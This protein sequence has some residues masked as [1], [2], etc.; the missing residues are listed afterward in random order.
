MAREFSRSD[1]DEAYDV[2]AGLAGAGN[3][4][5]PFPWWG[6][7]D[8]VDVIGRT[9]L[10]MALTFLASLFVIGVTVLQ[11]GPGRG[12][13]RGI[14]MIA[15]IFPVV[16]LLAEVGLFVAIGAGVLFR[17]EW[18]ITLFKILLVLICI[19]LF[20]V[21][22]VLLVLVGL[23]LLAVIR[24]PGGALFLLAGFGLCVLYFFGIVM[25]LWR[26]WKT[27]EV[28]YN[29][30]FVPCR[31][32]QVGLFEN[33]RRFGTTL[34]LSGLAMLI[35]STL[36][37]FGLWGSFVARRIL[38]VKDPTAFVRSI[39]LLSAATFLPALII[40]MGYR[41][42]TLVLGLAALAVANI[43]SAF[44][45]LRQLED[46]AEFLPVVFLLF[47][48][49]LSSAMGFWLLAAGIGYRQG[50]DSARVALQGVAVAG[51]ALIAGA[52]ILGF[53][54]SAMRFDKSE[55]LMMNLGEIAG[56]LVP[57]F[58]MVVPVYVLF[59]IFRYFRSDKAKAWCGAGKY[60]PP[61]KWQLEHVREIKKEDD[62]GYEKMMEEKMRDKALDRAVSELEEVSEEKPEDTGKEESGQ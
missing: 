48:I 30:V 9:I 21:G 14:E 52:V 36:F 5:R 22:I 13:P 4:G 44:V 60:A 51:F 38:N 62:E 16:M 6:P 56:M 46:R 7:F 41:T 61:W 54:F 57:M 23:A 59:E 58:Q 11:A 20:I 42:V 10:L 15:L 47:F 25:P 40:A 37:D 27:R 12:M 31:T 24:G 3:R 32:V 45:I 2:L 39:V 53:V 19:P 18:A 26:F 28:R 8:A 49:F 50:A 29:F 55:V 34:I 33:T 1:K 17:R 35:V 43:G